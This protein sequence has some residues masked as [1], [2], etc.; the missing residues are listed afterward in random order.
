MSRNWIKFPDPFLWCV[1]PEIDDLSNLSCL[2]HHTS[3]S[4]QQSRNMFLKVLNAPIQNKPVYFTFYQY[5]L[6]T[7]I[8]V[9][10]Q[11]QRYILVRRSNDPFAQQHFSRF[12]HCKGLRVYHFNVLLFFRPVFPFAE[13]ISV[14]SIELAFLPFK[15]T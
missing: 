5:I 14:D 1:G 9:N 13:L 8:F 6:C 7:C 15:V 10:F 3:T 2:V 12:T 4:E 11:G